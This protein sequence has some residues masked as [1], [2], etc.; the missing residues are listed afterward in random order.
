MAAKN[1]AAFEMTHNDY[2]ELVKLFKVTVDGTGRAVESDKLN[3][4][5]MMRGYIVEPNACTT[6]VESFIKDLDCNIN[7]TF[8]KTF[9]EVTS[10][11]RFELFI[12][13][14]FHYMTTYGTDFS[15]GNGYVPNENP[16]NAEYISL[17][18]DY[19]VIKSVTDAVMFEKCINMLKSGIAMKQSTLYPI[20]KFVCNY[21]VNHTEEFKAGFCIDLVFNKEAVTLICDWLNIAPNRKF[22]LFRYIIYKT[23]GS[24]TIIKN[25]ELINR[26]KTS[27]NQFDFTILTD[28]QINSLASIFYRFK[29]LF[30]AFK[31]QQINW[32]TTGASANAPIINKIRRRAVKYHTPFDAPIESTI[33]SKVYD[34]DKLMLIASGMNIYQ[35]VRLCNACV[36]RIT[37]INEASMYL[38]R[39]GRMFI[40]DSTTDYSGMKKYYMEV[41]DV[42]Y[43]ELR[44][45]LM[46]NACYVKYNKGINIAVPTSEKNFVGDIPFGSFI[47][48]ADHAMIG[49]YWRNEWGTRDFDL[50]MTDIKGNK[51]GWNSAYYNNDNSVV[52]SGDMTSADP[53]ATEILYYKNTGPQG[54]INI[55]RYSGN[56]GSKYKL[57]VAN[58]DGKTTLRKNYMVDPTHITFDAMCVSDTTQQ[59]IGLVNGNCF[60]I[61]NVGDGY[62]QVSRRNGNEQKA[63]DALSLKAASHILLGHLLRDAGYIDIDTVEET[64][65]WK[66]PE[67]AKIIDLTTLSR[68]TLINIMEGNI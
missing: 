56:D 36:E 62:G 39:N 4:L 64:D 65:D 68:D 55:N 2:V 8:Y 28:A 60:T 61:M 42:L 33:L 1:Y 54:F 12:D 13:Q 34:R 22:D 23:T 15:L 41:Y 26:I 38:V 63:F 66:I 16:E 67:D 47:N 51:I 18:R 19:T 6:I 9:E 5:A 20:C 25:R 24:T 11:T 57:F 53:E 37:R 29:P 45:R 46:E 59:V 31:K 3:Q 35:V 32:R 21:Y 10:K 27:S 49:I 14:V 52:Y 17:L 48:I 7:S 44:C 43:D 58:E 30:L 40:K 50:S